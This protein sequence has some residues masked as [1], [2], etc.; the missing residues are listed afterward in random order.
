M[1]EQW[2]LQ[3]WPIDTG[4]SIVGQDGMPLAYGPD[5]ARSEEISRQILALPELIEALSDLLVIC[6][7][8]DSK[9]EA[10]ARAAIAKAIG[11]T[12]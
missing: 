10:R 1:A 12:I 8:A 3:R 4:W 6:Y 5:N 9:V 11:G 7:C 2:K